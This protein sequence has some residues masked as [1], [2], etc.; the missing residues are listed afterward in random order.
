MISE[1]LI[2]LSL[3]AITTSITPG[4]NNIML[5]ASGVNF[6]LRRS[7]PHTLGISSGF[8]VLLLSVGFGLGFLFTNFPILHT[9]LKV[10]GSLYMLYLAFRIASSRSFNPK[11]Q[12]KSKP[13][14]FLEAALFQWVN[15]K[16]WVMAIS[17]MTL[18]TSQAQ[19]YLS[20]LWVSIVFSLLN[21]PS[22]SIWAVF[23]TALRGFLSDPVRLKWFNIAMGVALAASVALIL[24]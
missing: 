1:T 8:C 16:A 4:P 7:L 13:M 21:W 10:L 20:V 11:E 24:R 22:C 23:G 5:L 6:G 2:A 19:P 17:S 3:F 14:T 12:K 18:Y 9:V 15:P